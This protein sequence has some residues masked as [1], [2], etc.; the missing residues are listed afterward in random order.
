MG[1][2]MS[3]KTRDLTERFLAWR[4]RREWV[5][6]MASH[7]YRG[8]GLGFPMD[9]HAHHMI[10]YT[11]PNCQ[12]YNGYGA[13]ESEHVRENWLLAAVLL[14][15]LEDCGMPPQEGKFWSGWKQAAI[16]W[17]RGNGF[18][19]GLVSVEDACV[20]LDILP[21]R[22]LAACEAAHGAFIGCEPSAKNPS[23]RMSMR[24]RKLKRGCVP[25]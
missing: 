5:R 19:G 13:S 16:E 1:D 20:A 2:L 14:R 17:V 15:A 23:R 10:G 24:A 25:R 6:T 7:V 22:Y 11:S 9:V 18:I 12:S 4:K 3:Q 8:L 21:E